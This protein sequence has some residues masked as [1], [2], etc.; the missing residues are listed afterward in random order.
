MKTFAFAAAT[1]A[2]LA[3]SASAAIEDLDP[4]VRDN[5]LKGRIA[6]ELPGSATVWDAGKTHTATWT[7]GCMNPNDTGKEFPI[8]L[9]HGLGGTDQKLVP[10]I[11]N[12]GMLTCVKE[13]GKAAVTL[14]ANLVTS[15]KYAIWVGTTPQSFS[16]PF[17][18]KG[19]DPPKTSTPVSQPSVA[20]SPSASDATAAP[21]TTTEK[22]PSAAG[23]LQIAT[24]LVA[25]LAVAVGALMA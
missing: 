4:T 24:S 25:G 15:D 10:N 8:A 23:S 21:Q 18:I 5:V 17:T 12:V 16:V 3:T 20:P 2:V 19:I 11:T 6:F 13:N 1:I 7:Y 9:Y 22:P 14:P